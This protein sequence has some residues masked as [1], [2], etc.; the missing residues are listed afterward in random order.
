MLDTVLQQHIYSS[1]DSAA[2]LVAI[3]IATEFIKN[4]EAH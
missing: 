1:A 2:R 4:I 3:P